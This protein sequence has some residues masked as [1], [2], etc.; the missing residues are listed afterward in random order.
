MGEL[1]W[2][3]TWVDASAGTCVERSVSV[4]RV[5]GPL[6]ALLVIAQ[7]ILFAYKKN[8]LGVTSNGELL[9]YSITHCENG[10]SEVF[11]FFRKG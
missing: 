11:V 6:K 8:V 4:K 1:D 7:S 3:E 10:P 9:I 2:Q 5:M